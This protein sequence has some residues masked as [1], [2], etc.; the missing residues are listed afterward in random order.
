MSHVIHV[1]RECDHRLQVHVGVVKL[2]GTVDEVD[3]EVH[4]FVAMPNMICTG[5]I[6]ML[7]F[8]D[9]CFFAIVGHHAVKTM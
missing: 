4:G 7:I 3:V 1:E 9:L 8:D 5:K 2:S 6:K